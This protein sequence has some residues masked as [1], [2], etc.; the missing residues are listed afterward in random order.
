M[1]ESTV[2]VE[3]IP[4]RELLDEAMKLT[5]RHFG[6]I[7]LLVAVPLAL[8]ATVTVVLQSRYLQEMAG[9]RGAA[10]MVSGR[11]CLTFIA[12]L[13]LTMIVQGLTSGVLTAAAVDGA[14]GRPIDIKANWAFILQPRS[15]GTL[16]L[17]L[18]V[19]L[20]GFICLIIPG[21][22]LMLGLSFVVPVMAAERLFGSGALGRSWK[23]VRYNPHKGF[24]KNTPTKIFLLY[25]V[26]GLI[27]YAVTFFIQLPFSAMQG[28]RV[29]RSVASGA[30]ANPQAIYGPIWMRMASAILGSLTTT[31]VYIYSSFGIVL[32]Y[33]DVVR[34]KEGS[35]LAAAIDARFGG[36]PAPPAAPRG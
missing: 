34:R 26:A 6:A 4:F 3:P 30:A 10:A 7:Y 33:Q 28:V 32:L 23:L 19:I 36:Q 20:A 2:P 35:D 29:A 1:T 27:A 5:R 31:A 15:L 17:S 12:S 11:G 14:S 13:A 18:V 9:P 24:L 21:V 16:F 8:L 25:L 22:Y